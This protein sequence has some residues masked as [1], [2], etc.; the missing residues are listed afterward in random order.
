MKVFFCQWFDVVRWSY[1]QCYVKAESKDQALTT[2]MLVSKIRLQKDNKPEFIAREV[3]YPI[4]DLKEIVSFDLDPLW[5]EEGD[6]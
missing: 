1:M 5:D 3:M 2:I 6:D 4:F